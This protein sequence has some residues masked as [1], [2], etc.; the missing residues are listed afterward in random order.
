MGTY[1][2]VFGVGDR[3]K[4]FGR[5]VVVGFVDGQVDHETVG[6][7]SVPV[8]FADFEQD[9]IAGAD[10]LDRSAAALAQPHSLGHEDGLTESSSPS[11][12]VLVFQDWTSLRSAAHEPS[13]LSRSALGEPGSAV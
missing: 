11:T 4:P 9:W 13:S 12:W 5:V 2:E 8:F 10:D 6:C 3:R 7:G 1:H